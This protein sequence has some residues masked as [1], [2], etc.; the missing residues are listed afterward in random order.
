MYNYIIFDVDGTLLDT[1]AAVL[2]SL[3]KLVFKELGKSLS[4]D[5]LK[6]ALGIPGE[7][8][9]KELGI[10]DV[11]DCNI[12]WNRYFK[13][14]FHFVKVF[15]DIEDTLIGLH[16]MGVSL[17]IVTSKTRE[18]F[19]NDFGIF[20]L[21][22]YFHIVVCADDTEKHKPDP[23]PI[24][25]FIELACKDKSKIIYIGDTE[26]DMKCASGSGIDFALALWGAKTSKGINAKYFLE[27]P[28]EILEL[29]K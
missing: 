6:F 13:E 11:C 27:N 28:K 8:A 14:Y 17:G 1:E 20:G 4:F 2:S 3:Q 15:D 5:D 7:V 21:N 16:K 26:Y 12:K 22:D 29:V 9:L 23:E 24:L 25:K 10:I 18:E 19:A